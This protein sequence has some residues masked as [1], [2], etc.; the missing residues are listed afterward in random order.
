[1]VNTLM[2][3]GAFQKDLNQTEMAGIYQTSLLGK[4]E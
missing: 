4:N 3:S 2:E 1:M